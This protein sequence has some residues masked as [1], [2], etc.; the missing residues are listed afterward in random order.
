MNCFPRDLNIIVTNYLNTDKKSLKLLKLFLIDEKYYT[1]KDY[2]LFA[3]IINTTHKICKLLVF[4][5]NELNIVK[6]MNNIKE[7]ILG[8]LLDD[9]VSSD[10]FPKKLTHL[11]F[12]ANFDQPI[13]DLPKQLTHLVFGWNFNQKLD[14]LPKGLNYLTVG[15]NFSRPT[16]LLQYPKLKEIGIGTLSQKNL[17]KNVPKK[18]KFVI[19]QPQHSI[20][21]EPI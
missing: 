15:D 20:I 16:D 3:E 17:F 10:I 18:C 12:S 14:N 5:E 4:D 8:F 9:T 13:I 11:R 21:G 19:Y 1:S 2:H 6:N 7:L